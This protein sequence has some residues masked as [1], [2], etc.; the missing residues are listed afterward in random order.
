MIYDVLVLKSKPIPVRM[1]RIPEEIIPQNKTCY[2]QALRMKILLLLAVLIAAT[3]QTT[4]QNPA[5]TRPGANATG[6]GKETPTQK[7]LRL[8]LNAAHAAFAAARTVEERRRIWQQIIDLGRLKGNADRIAN[9]AKTVAGQLEMARMNAE[10]ER[11]RA[12]R[13]AQYRHQHVS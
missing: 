5:P 2:F 1:P 10:S 11:L 4:A 12:E 3:I 13:H 6:F 8:K 9:D 7:E